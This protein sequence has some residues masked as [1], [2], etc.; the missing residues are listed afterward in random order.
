LPIELTD[1]SV[2]CKD[3]LPTLTWTTATEINNDYFTIER[4]VDAINFTPVGFVQGAGNSNTN[5]SYTWIDDNPNGARY[6]RLKQTDFDGSYEY[7]GIKASECGEIS[8]L[9][10]YPNPFKDEFTLILPENSDFPYTVE[11]IDYLGK[12]V[13]TEVI[14]SQSSNIKLK[15]SI[16]G[17]VYFVKVYNESFQLTERLIKTK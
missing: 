16:S 7:H 9:S 1:F 4:S 8:N 3:G 17:G 2:G 14:K 13:H 15:E 10:V 12:V 6:Y 5:I 11:L